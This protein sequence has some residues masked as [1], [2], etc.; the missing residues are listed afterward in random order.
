MGKLK[1]KSQNSHDKQRLAVRNNLSHVPA[2]GKLNLG[3][4]SLLIETLTF[5][6]RR[7][8]EGADNQN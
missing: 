3:I 8:T 6:S 2:G 4:G 5:T 1:K 7:V